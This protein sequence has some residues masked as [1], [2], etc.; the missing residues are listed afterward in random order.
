[1]LHLSSLAMIIR[2][3]SRKMEHFYQRVVLKQLQHLPNMLNVV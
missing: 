1:M 3:I 2:F